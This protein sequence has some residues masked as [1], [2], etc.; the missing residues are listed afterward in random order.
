MMTPW[1]D[2]VSKVPAG[3]CFQRFLPSFRPVTESAAGLLFSSRIARVRVVRSKACY[4]SR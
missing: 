3:V 1:H 2:Q 4:Y